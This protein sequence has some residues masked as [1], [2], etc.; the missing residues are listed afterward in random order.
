MENNPILFIYGPTGSGKSNLAMQISQLVKNA[1]IVNCDASQV[2][3]DVPIITASP[4]E[5]DKK[6]I[7]H[8]LY[9]Y[10]NYNENYC[11]KQYLSD[12]SKIILEQINIGNKVIVTGGSNF[13][14]DVLVNGISDMPEISNQVENKIKKDLNDIGLN[15]IY[16]ILIKSLSEKYKK[17][18]H[19]NDKYRVLRAY[20]VLLQT[21]KSIEFFHNNKKHDKSF[22]LENIIKKFII[23]DPNRK[24]LY[25]TCNNRLNLLLQDGGFEE[26]RNLLWKKNIC[27]NIIN[28]IPFKEISKYVKKQITYQDMLSMSKQRTRNYAK[29]QITWLKN[30]FIKQ[31]NHQRFFTNSIEELDLTKLINKIYFS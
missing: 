30:Y 24:H 7:P 31:K 6:K 14:L 12:A 28:I 21:G 10:L 8:F 26:I 5:K 13:Y 4:S 16:N 11:V 19:I 18:I 9:N 29:R 20:K 23:L 17:K 22:S 2:Y 15:G 27:Q 25:K 3:K 1:V